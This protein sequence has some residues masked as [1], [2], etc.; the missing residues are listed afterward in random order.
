MPEATD[1]TDTTAGS[2]S[3]HETVDAA[4]ESEGVRSPDTPADEST[5]QSEPETFP[6]A[7]VE[8]LRAENARYRERAKT[9]DGLAQRLHTELVRAT[10]RLQDPSD[11]PY[12][13]EH[14]DDPDTLAAAL[15]DLL[16]RKPHLKS[17]RPV[18]DVGQGAGGV[19]AGDVNLAEMLRARA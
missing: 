14:L 15:D 19:K 12:A 7:Y 1:T 17:R 2:D 3:D 4:T 16:E 18:G 11:L 5:E 9:A 10:G 13:E 8:E 6:R